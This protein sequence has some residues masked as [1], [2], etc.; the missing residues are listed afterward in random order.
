[1]GDQKMNNK[2]I[3]VVDDDEDICCTIKQY[4]ELHHYQIETVHSGVEALKMMNNDFDLIVLDIMMEGIDGMELCRLIRDRV[5][6]PIVFVSAKTLEEDKV[7]AL[8]I[9][10]DDYITKPFS[11]KEL[12]ARIDSHLRREERIRSNERYLLSSKNI[13]IDLLA[14]EVFCKGKKLPFTKKEYE[15]VKLLMLNKKVVFSKERIFERVWGI[16]SD[17]QLDTVTES[18]KNIRK[19]IKAIDPDTSYIQTLYGL[20]YKWDVTDEKQ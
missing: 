7:Q 15:I 1:M 12:K 8:A 2:K 6:V 4:L 9:G 5:D 16:D 19:K 20:G 13:T 17:S 10:G 11:L 3:L 18:I 14:N